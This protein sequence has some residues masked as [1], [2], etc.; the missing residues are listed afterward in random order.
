MTSRRRSSRP[1]D[2]VGRPELHIDNAWRKNR[3]AD[4]DRPLLLGVG[5]SAD[6]TAAGRPSGG[7]AMK[8]FTKQKPADIWD[9]TIEGPLG[10][11]E[12]ADRIRAICDAAAARARPVPARNDQARNRT[13]RARGQGGDGNRHE[14][15]RWIDARRRRAPDRRSL[16]EGRT[17]SR[18]RRS[19]FARS[20]PAGSVRPCSVITRNRWRK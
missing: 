18:P 17:T 6:N 9:E 2:H 11:I 1:S 5:G 4:L 3:L 10:D 13:V 14:D 15:F 7:G 12:A 19:C 16:P 8:W 20:M